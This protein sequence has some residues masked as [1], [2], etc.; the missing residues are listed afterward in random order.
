MKWPILLH[1]EKI[2]SKELAIF[3]AKYIRLF[4]KYSEPILCVSFGSIAYT[5]NYFTTFVFIKQCSLM[6]CKCFT[7]HNIISKGPNLNSHYA[8][9]YLPK[10]ATLHIILNLPQIIFWMLHWQ[11]LLFSSAGDHTYLVVSWKTLDCWPSFRN[12]LKVFNTASW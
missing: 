10:S 5:V 9:I 6:H 7:L 3:F 11:K 8:P 12:I 1:D 2:T 4:V